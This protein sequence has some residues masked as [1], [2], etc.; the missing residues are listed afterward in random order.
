MPTFS[1][2]RRQS[3]SL[4]KNHV[5]TDRYV[6]TGT[7]YT[8]LYIPGTNR[9]VPGTCPSDSI[10]CPT[11][12][13]ITY[14]LV[15]R[16][17]T[18]KRNTR[19][20]QYLNYTTFP[21]LVLVGN[22]LF[23]FGAL[24]HNPP[25]FL[26]LFYDKRQVTRYTIPIIDIRKDHPLVGDGSNIPLFTQSK[27]FSNKINQPCHLRQLLASK[28]RCHRKV[29]LLAKATTTTTMTP[30]VTNTNSTMHLPCRQ[31]LQ[32]PLP[33]NNTRQHPLHHHLPSGI[34]CIHNR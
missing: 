8:V 17:I 16:N 20:N 33:L 22:R 6:Y 18:E 10:S 3:C 1:D 9:Y 21:G 28:L 26:L 23:F 14:V 15:R 29:V 31:R 25:S 11:R 34:H 7:V 2:Y 24:T 4:C 5:S 13:L 30:R 32:S 12:L 27:V 19:S